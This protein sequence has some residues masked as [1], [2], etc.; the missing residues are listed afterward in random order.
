MTK[1]VPLVVAALG[2]TTTVSV[3]LSPFRAEGW[4]HVIVTPFA[5]SETTVGS[6]AVVAKRD[7]VA[8]SVSGEESGA[9]LKT[10]TSTFVVSPFFATMYPSAFGPPKGVFAG[11][12]VCGTAA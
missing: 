8:T 2:S 11:M 9:V 4:D 3:G 7:L 1:R 5:T 6:V 10:S 12:T